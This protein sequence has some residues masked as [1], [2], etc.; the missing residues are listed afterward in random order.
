MT[1]KFPSVG[2]AIRV[3]TRTY[4]VEAVEPDTSG[5]TVVRLACLDDDAQGQHLEVVWEL[6]LDAEILNSEAWQTIGRKGFDEPRF[7][8]AYM[9]TLRWN[10]VTATD[11]RLFQAPFRA[12][13]R[14]D[15]Y[16][17]E[18]LRKALLLPRVNLF[19]ADDV[20]LGKT[21]EAGLIARELLLRR[22]VREIVVACPP[23]MLMQWKD[24]LETR[25]GLV[26]EILDR[27]YIERVRRERGYGVNPWTTYPRFLISH[28]LLID[29]TYTTPLRDW[30]DNIRP[31]SLLIFD[32]AHH[33]APASGAKYAI[34]SRI[35]R[36]IRDLGFRFEH[37]L[38][39]SATPHNGHSNS[40]SALLELLDPQRFTRGVKVL[41]S[42]LDSVMVR[43]LK[44]DIRQIA[45]GFPKRKVQQIDIAG[46]PENAPEL[47]LSQ[48]LEKYRQARSSRLA[49]ATKRQQAQA[50][51]LVSHL[52]QRLLSSIEAFARTLAVHRRTMERIWNAP[53][54]QPPSTVPRL[55]LLQDAPD[56]EDDRSLLDEEEQEALMAEQVEA[57]TAATAGGGSDFSK[58]KALL[59]EMQNV[60]E[61][62][63]GLPDARVRKLIQWIHEK[64]CPGVRMPGEACPKPGAA[65]NDLRLLIFTEY[66]DTKRYLVGMLR[67]AIADTDMAEH[68]IEVFHGPTPPDKREAIKRAF[69]LPPHEHPIRILVATDAAR[70]G[71]NLQAHCHNLFHFDVPWNPS[72]LEQRNGRIDRK[73]QPAPEVFCHYFVYVQRP[74]DRVL[75]TLVLKTERIR[76]ELG[77]LA[78]VLE[79]RLSESIRLGIAHDQVDRIEREIDDAGLDP[80]KRQVAEEEL[81]ATRERQEALE[82]QIDALRNRINESRK[83]I[84]LD[85]EHFRDA[86]SCSLELLGAAPLRALPAKNGAPPCYAFPDLDTRHGADPSW[87]VTLD[88]LRVP[89]ED[90]QRSFQ[91][92]RAAPVRPVIFEAPEGIDQDTVHLHLEHRVAQRLLG[93]FQAQGFIHHDLSRAC[94]AHT[95]DAI[96]RV[97]LLGRLSLYGPGAIRLHEEVITVTARWIESGTRRGKLAPYAREAEAKT[98]D[99]L[100]ESLAPGAHPKVPDPVRAKLQAAIAGDIGELLPHLEQRGEAAKADAEKRLAERGR[101][102]SE[103]MR[104]VLEDQRKRVQNELGRFKEIQ[105]LLDLDIEKKQLDSNRRYWER[106]LENVDGDL[107]REPARILDFYRVASTRVEPVGLAYL[108]PVTG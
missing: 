35:T 48:L 23:S 98:L 57:V 68:R 42:N 90:G 50:A 24:E 70:E 65:W 84:G 105:L 103:A 29:E 11:P 72:R 88:T 14:I 34:D 17:L 10:C 1:P 21:I 69:N 36:A 45:G 75:R 43:R 9:H 49:D 19:I 78:E 99:L 77:S 31:G 15:A 87:S 51:L 106:W 30:L 94:L 58:E 100:E 97:V 93:R 74:E 37:R 85:I 64:M 96:P 6:E 32:E 89:P 44:E 80:E 63:R 53:T 62:A 22:R 108:W 46:L 33:V 25:F 2:D 7:F 55:D 54:G 82:R 79:S 73:L 102:E 38:F 81:E 39:L 16:Q 8:S 59:T 40:F 60:A 47:K 67:A 3:R 91:W 107:K 18:P 66:D 26:F 56:R 83:W 52:Q 5:T 95:G 20:G 28:R 71:I 92:R 12:G 104:K 4:L 13:I 76:E 101:I 27:H 86:L 61:S 41:K